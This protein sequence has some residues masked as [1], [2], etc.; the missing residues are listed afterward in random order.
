VL[1]SEAGQLL[2]SSDGGRQFTLRP[3]PQPYPLSALAPAAPGRIV[4]VGLLGAQ[5]VALDGVAS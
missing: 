1:A 3:A 4:A 5:I 2:V